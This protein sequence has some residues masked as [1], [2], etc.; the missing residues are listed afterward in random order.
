MNLWR[1]FVAELRREAIL[2]VRYPLE[3]VSRL[4]WN[5]GFALLIFFGFSAAVGSQASA[6]PGFEEGNVGRLLGLLTTYIAINGLGNAAELISEEVQTGTLEQAALSPPPLVLV[7][8]LRDLASYVEMLL[9][10]ALVLGIACLVTGVRLHLDVPAYIVLLSLMYLGMEGI[11]LM[12]GGASLIAKRIATLS[13][14]AVMLVFGLAIVPLGDLPA[15]ARPFVTAFPFTNALEQLRAVAV[16][17]SGLAE[18]WLAG[19]LPNLLVGALVWLVAGL[20]VFARAERR[21]RELGT[22]NQY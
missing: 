1:L 16:G 22:L 14:F 2:L 5:L 12:L 8:L 20:L 3:T 10:F 15:W 18:L 17:G 11:G 6:L 4:V 21:A 19:R 7:V 13:Q 9:R